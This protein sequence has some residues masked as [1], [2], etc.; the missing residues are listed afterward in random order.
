MVGVS[1][2]IN[3]VFIHRKLTR[4]MGE[5]MVRYTVKI[6]AKFDE[7]DAGIGS[8]FELDAESALIA[9]EKAMIAMRESSMEDGSIFHRIDDFHNAGLL[10]ITV[11]VSED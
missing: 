4:K 7:G 5:N 10:S 2:E 9:V 8:S 3:Y 11:Q 6:E 1:G